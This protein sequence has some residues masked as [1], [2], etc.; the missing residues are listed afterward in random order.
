MTEVLNA[1]YGTT[2]YNVV[3]EL[4]RELQVKVKQKNPEQKVGDI[5]FR[6]KA[7]SAV[8]TQTFVAD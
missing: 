8:V 3:E 1:K 4:T 6:L 5:S 2:A 7:I